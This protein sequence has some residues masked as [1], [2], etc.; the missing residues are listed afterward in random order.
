M[1]QKR[2]LLGSKNT[3]LPGHARKLC[4]L[5]QLLEPTVCESCYALILP[6]SP[7]YPPSQPFSPLV[8]L[9]CTSG[10]CVSPLIFSTHSHTPFPPWL[11]P[12]PSSRITPC[13][14]LHG[15]VTFSLRILPSIFCSSL[16]TSPQDKKFSHK[17]TFDRIRR[18]KYSFFFSRLLPA[19]R[20]ELTLTGCRSDLVA[21]ACPPKL[22]SGCKIW[23][24]R[25]LFSYLAC[26]CT[27]Q[28]VWSL[29]I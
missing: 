27:M 8:T 7:G 11:H 12:T 1:K 29:S 15:S 5:V 18:Q 4:P 28:F 6:S 2:N 22:P 10:L 3:E 13:K 19:L 17:T 16:I 21:T 24:A 23:Q 14:R 9:S 25:Q 20:S 26:T